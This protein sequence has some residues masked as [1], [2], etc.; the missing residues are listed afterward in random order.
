[1]D[2][3]A[4]HHARSSGPAIFLVIALPT[5]IPQSSGLARP[6]DR[7]LDARVTPAHDERR[8]EDLMRMGGASGPQ[9]PLMPQA[10]D[11]D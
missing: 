7:P 8:R 3:I 4:M 11:I 9:Q 10:L 2:L 5:L 1:V 6:H